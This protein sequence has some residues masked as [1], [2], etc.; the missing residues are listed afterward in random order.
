[1]RGRM[2]L[3]MQKKLLLLTVSVIMG[4]GA[5]ALAAPS[6]NY[7]LG[8]VSVQAGINTVND[9]KTVM[10]SASAFNQLDT[11]SFDGHEKNKPYAGITVGLGHNMAI[12]YRYEQLKSNPD[13]NATDGQF[14]YTNKLKTQEYNF[15]YS[16]A[17]ILSVYAGDYHVKFTGSSDNP[18]DLAVHEK[19]KDYP[20]VG[21]TCVLP[22][23]ANFCAWADAGVGINMYH[24]E[25]GV[26]YK[27]A[28]NLCLDVSYKYLR[29][30]KVG[31]FTNISLTDVKVDGKTRGIRVGLT[32][33]F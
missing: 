7:D 25:V 24:Y 19:K 11:K 2:A 29:L 4:L 30:D 31:E 5:T 6:T 32:L 9:I 22:L 1:M 21:A 16:L 12:Q 17:K 15:R 28:K 13:V 23:V 8:R 20:H 26:G 3:A 10:K 18:N 14:S 33:D 27:I